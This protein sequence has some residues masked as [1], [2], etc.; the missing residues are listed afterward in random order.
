M[1]VVCVVIVAR[2]VR[3]ETKAAQHAAPAA[4]R[5]RASAAA[6]RSACCASSRHLQV[7]ALVIGFAALGAAHH[8]AAAQHGGGGVQGRR[9]HR[10]HHRVPR[11][12]SRFYL[13]IDRLRRPGRADQPHPPL[14]RASASRCWSCRSASARRGCVILLNGALWAPALARVLDTSL[15]YTLDKTTREVLFLPLPADAEVPGEAVRRRHR[16]SLREGARRAAGAR[17]DQAVGARPRLAAD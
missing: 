12:R 9:R 5:R 10:R 17:A 4:A 7:I 16:G 15:R 6:K 2:I 14:A 1:L 8:R 13:S 3:R 11:R